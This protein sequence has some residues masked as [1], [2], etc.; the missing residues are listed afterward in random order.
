MLGHYGASCGLSVH[1]A[2]ALPCVLL[3]LRLAESRPMPFAA[4]ATGLTALTG[5]IVAPLPR[6]PLAPRQSSCHSL[7]ICW[8]VVFACATQPIPWLVLVCFQGL[9]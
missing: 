3:M 5:T 1:Q 2:R 8:S 7:E 6:D 9:L 4:H